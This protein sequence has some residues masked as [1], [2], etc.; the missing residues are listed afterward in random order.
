MDKFLKIIGFS[1]FIFICSCLYFYFVLWLM[2][3]DADSPMVS[4]DGFHDNVLWT[5]V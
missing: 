5:S 2:L 3:I 1:V 4:F